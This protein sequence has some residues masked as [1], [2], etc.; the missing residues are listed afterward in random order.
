MASRKIPFFTA[1]AAIFFT[2]ALARNHLTGLTASNGI[3]G[4]NAYTCRTQAQ[5]CL[6]SIFFICLPTLIVALLQWNQLASDAKEQGFSAV[7]I[8]GFDCDALERASS[9][10]A[11]AGLQVLAGIWVS[12][13]S[14]SKH[15]S[16]LQNPLADCIQGT[17]T[18]S[19]VQ[20]KCALPQ[21]FIFCSST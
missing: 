15:P 18:D 2:S 4:N 5:A 13:S 7:R 16:F 8:E 21:N 12:V 17:I 1:L 20:I 9:A 11:D 6:V 19:V 10:A 3:G 14:P